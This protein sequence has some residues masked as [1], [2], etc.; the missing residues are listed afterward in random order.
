MPPHLLPLML[1]YFLLPHLAR[2]VPVKPVGLIAIH[3][4]VCAWLDEGAMVVGLGEGGS[5]SEEGLLVQLLVPH[6]LTLLAC[7]WLYVVELGL[8]HSGWAVGP[9]VKA[10]SR[11]G[12]VKRGAN[13]SDNRLTQQAIYTRAVVCVP[14]LC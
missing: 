1:L 12:S 3:R 8:A 11:D 10:K 9:R 14:R 13:P 2:N 6:C 5:A 7:A 4:T